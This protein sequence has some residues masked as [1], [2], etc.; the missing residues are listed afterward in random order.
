MDPQP[1]QQHAGLHHAVWQQQQEVTRPKAR[2][3]PTSPEKS[4]GMGEQIRCQ[5]ILVLLFIGSNPNQS[6]RRSAV[7]WYIPQWRVF[8]DVTI[9][10]NL[11]LQDDDHVLDVLA[12]T[13]LRPKFLAAPG[14]GS[15]WSTNW[16]NE[17]SPEIFIWDNGKLCRFA[18]ELS[19]LLLYKRVRIV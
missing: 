5:H 12:R 3:K 6:N 7:Q 2:F 1:S 8:S 19:L 9:K 13:I 4:G 18:I 14:P 17:S 15:D 10:R 11:N 16:V